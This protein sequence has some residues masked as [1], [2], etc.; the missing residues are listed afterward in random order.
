MVE[1]GSVE[2]G[3]VEKGTIAIALVREALLE[4]SRSRPPADWLVAAGIAPALLDDPGARVTAE[5]YASLWR[6]IAHRLDDEFF[7][8]DPRRM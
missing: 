5:E 2:K 8:M 3:A 6:L 7:G 4:P 1:K